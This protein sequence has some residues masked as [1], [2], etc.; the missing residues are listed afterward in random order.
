MTCCRRHKGMAQG[1]PGQQKVPGQQ[2]VSWQQQDGKGVEV[3]T[4]P[5]T[6]KK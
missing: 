5:D 6:S 4:L 1:S 2:E 3:F